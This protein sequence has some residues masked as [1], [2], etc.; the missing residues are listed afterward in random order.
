MRTAAPTPWSLSWSLT[1]F[2]ELFLVIVQC[3]I[4]A[5]A[6]SAHPDP[7]PLRHWL[8]A[9]CRGQGKRKISENDSLLSPYSPHPSKIGK[10]TALYRLGWG[11]WHQSFSNI[12]VRRY[13]CD[14]IPSQTLPKK[15]LKCLC[16]SWI[17]PIPFPANCPSL[18]R[19]RQIDL[20]N[21]LIE[22]GHGVAPLGLLHH[23]GL[24]AQGDVDAGSC[25]LAGLSI[26]LHGD[27]LG[28]G[29]NHLP[30]LTEPLP[31]ATDLQGSL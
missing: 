28:R 18:E 3:L 15:G 14:L 11:A 5:H 31:V 17:S 1:G 10:S 16:Q 7:Q 24:V 12:R 30:A 9:V 4:V 21:L 27:G 22:Q 26:H 6:D 29:E 19:R 13:F 2:L 8:L 20:R 23:V 25:Q